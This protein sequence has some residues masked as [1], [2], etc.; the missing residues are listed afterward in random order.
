MHDP[1]PRTMTSRK[2][3][4]LNLCRAPAAMSLRDGRPGERTDEDDPPASLLCARNLAKFGTSGTSVC[5][6]SST[7]R[8][9]VPFYYL[10]KG[11]STF[12]HLPV[13]GRKPALTSGYALQK[14][15][16]PVVPFLKHRN[17]TGRRS[18][19]EEAMLRRLDGRRLPPC[20]ILRGSHG[21]P[22]PEGIP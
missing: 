4:D 9:D 10:K 18:W 22:F 3:A 15:S 20:S 6:P 14:P 11:T 5:F 17:G 12:N 8:N 1:R 19:S 21:L 13:S 2:D 7:S 16:V